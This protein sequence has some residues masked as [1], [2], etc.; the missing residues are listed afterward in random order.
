MILT[1]TWMQS[2]ED[3]SSDLCKKYCHLS[4]TTE[5]S[6]TAMTFQ[7]VYYQ[8]VTNSECQFWQSYFERRMI[9]LVLR[10]GNDPMISFVAHLLCEAYLCARL[11]GIAYVVMP[12]KASLLMRYHSTLL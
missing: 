6:F 10:F 2:V 5:Y 8:N 1:L 4:G 9:G 3:P 7:F 11:T 12:S